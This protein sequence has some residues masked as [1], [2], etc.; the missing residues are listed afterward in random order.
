MVGR[1]A[2]EVGQVGRQVVVEVG[3]ELEEDQFDHPDHH[4]WRNP[5]KQ[6]VL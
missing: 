6:F 4:L 5:P 1:I 2:V 3:D